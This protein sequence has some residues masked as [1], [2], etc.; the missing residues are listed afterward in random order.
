[1]M[2]VAAHTGVFWLVRLHLEYR[3]QRV[4]ELTYRDKGSA[5][6]GL[7]WPHHGVGLSSCQGSFDPDRAVMVYE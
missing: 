2:P 7:R 5:F 3:V 4:E 1:M 6:S